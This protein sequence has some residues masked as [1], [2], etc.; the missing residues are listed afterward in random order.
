L[1]PKSSDWAAAGAAQIASAAMQ[2][3]NNSFV[4]CDLSFHATMS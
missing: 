3:F 4:L 2:I 1:V